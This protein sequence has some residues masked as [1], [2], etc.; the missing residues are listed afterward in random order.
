MAI[1]PDHTFPFGRPLYPDDHGGLYAGFTILAKERLGV[2]RFGTVVDWVAGS[3]HEMIVFANMIRDKTLG[4]FGHLPYDKATLPIRVVADRD[5][6]IIKLQLP[7]KAD[8]L[9]ANPEM[10]LALAEVI[11]EKVAT[12]LRPI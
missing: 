5:K 1:G 6:N 3:P 10:W 9:A 7:Q 8:V 2:L 11:D 4:A 12:L